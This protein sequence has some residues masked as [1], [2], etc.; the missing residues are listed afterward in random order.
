MT[1]PSEYYVVLTDGSYSKKRWG[2]S[3]VMYSIHNDIFASF[4][5][6]GNIDFY[7]LNKRDYIAFSELMGIYCA[8]KI[9]LFNNSCFN[10]TCIII[11]DNIDVFKMLY[12]DN[13]AS[14]FNNIVNIVIYKLLMA[15]II[16]KKQ[17][18]IIFKNNLND[19]ILSH[20]LR[21]T[22][23]S[24]LLSN[25]KSHGWPPDKNAGMARIHR[26]DNMYYIMDFNNPFLYNILNKNFI[27]RRSNFIKISYKN[28]IK[29]FSYILHSIQFNFNNITNNDMNTFNL[30]MVIWVFQDDKENSMSYWYNKDTGSIIILDYDN[31][32]KCIN[33]EWF[34]YKANTIK[35]WHNILTFEW[36]YI[37]NEHL[38]NCVGYIPFNEI[39]MIM[40]NDM[41]NIAHIKYT[42]NNA[43][44]LHCNDGRWCRCI[45]Q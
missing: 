40:V 7:N 36:F 14:N 34:C 44:L 8:I 41:I 12:S 22:R 4:S 30:R 6:G 21:T 33:N 17:V 35:I 45:H 24:E 13:E 2:S 32:D 9:L 42:N 11:T 28:I 16:T 27:M 3:A 29:K 38:E 19:D 10:K 1:S 26:N 43:T 5:L 18:K 25:I 39:N 37:V 15:M 23:S 31:F 20:V